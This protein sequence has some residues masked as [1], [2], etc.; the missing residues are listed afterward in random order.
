[1]YFLFPPESL[2]AP[3]RLMPAT[4]IVATERVPADDFK[5]DPLAASPRSLAGHYLMEGGD[6]RIE[7]VV[8]VGAS[9][10]L[11]DWRIRVEVEERVAGR[12]AVR[13]SFKEQALRQVEGFWVFETRWSQGVFASYQDGLARGQPAEPGLILDGV[14]LFLTPS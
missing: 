12:K 1:M 10:E 5:P 13:R 11:L 14:F 2:V 9:E 8:F 6:G 4:V 7:A 3:Q